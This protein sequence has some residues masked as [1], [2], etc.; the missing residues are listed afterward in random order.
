MSSKP[1][2]SS[3]EPLPRY[4]GLEG[5]SDTCALARLAKQNPA[6]Q[7]LAVITA[8]ALDAQRLLEE[9]PFFAPDLR[10]SLLP[11]VGMMFFPIFTVYVSDYYDRKESNS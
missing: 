7:L 10:V 8:S 6:G 9:I 4:I 11:V 2:S 5:S 3:S 1:N